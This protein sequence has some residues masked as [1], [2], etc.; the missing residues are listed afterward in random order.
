MTPRGR[1]AL[2]SAML[3]TDKV[4]LRDLRLSWRAIRDIDG[5][6]DEAGHRLYNRPV[7]LPFSESHEV[8]KR[9][10]DLYDMIVV[11]DHNISRHLSHGGSA[12]FF[13]VARE[14]LRP[15]EGCVALRKRDMEWL[16]PRI[17]PR[18]VMHVE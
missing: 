7:T 5:W 12:I 3:R 17:G 10:D 15:T 8:L 4:R 1:F 2:L 13:H 16:L 9:Q 14:D 18:T 11:M 6:C